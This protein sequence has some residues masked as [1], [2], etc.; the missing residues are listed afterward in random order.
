[1]ETQ[2]AIDNEEEGAGAADRHGNGTLR[3]AVLGAVAMIVAGLAIFGAATL[4]G[5]GV[6]F[7]RAQTPA[8]MGQMMGS[9]SGGGSGGD[10]QSMIGNGQGMA[11]MDQMV[12][13]C[14]QHMQEMLSMMQTMQAQPGTTPAP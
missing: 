2:R 11:T 10:M 9:M 5:R 4:A 1:M 7:A 13:L 14:T 12:Q 8:G 6:G 3:D